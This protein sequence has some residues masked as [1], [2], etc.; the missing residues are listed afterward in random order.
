MLLAALSAAAAL[1]AATAAP[2]DPRMADLE[3]PVRP[4]VRRTLCL[5][6]L[7]RLPPCSP[8]V[9]A[10]TSDRRTLERCPVS[11]LSPQATPLIANDPYFQTYSPRGSLTDYA[12]VAGTNGKE[13]QISAIAFIEGHVCQLIGPPEKGASPAK[14]L[15]VVVYPT[16]TVYELMC[17]EAWA[18]K[19]PF[20]VTFMTAQLPSNLTLMAR[21]VSYVTFYSKPGAGSSNIQVYVD[22]SYQATSS[23]ANGDSVNVACGTNMT[24]MGVYTGWLGNAAT[25][26]TP[27]PCA[28]PLKCREGDNI[29]WG[30]LYLAQDGNPVGVGK[31]A[32]MRSKF[33]SAGTLADSNGCSSPLSGDDMPVL[34]TVFDLNNQND[35]GSPISVIFGYDQDVAIRWWGT[36]FPGLWTQESDTAEEM[37]AL[38][39][40]ETDHVSK[41][42]ETFDNAEVDKYNKIGGPKF[43]TILSLA[44]RQAYSS[45][46]LAW[47]TE[48]QTHWQ[49]LKEISTGA[50]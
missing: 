7:L 44:Y 34:A 10:P 26:S 2:V 6:H 31:S 8:R 30:Q 16:R 3:A 35:P 46:K 13:Q 42:C 11:P 22:A 28:D 19:T 36:D 21:P 4:R 29:N 23:P 27:I 41:L 20:T 18:L 39:V 50:R 17:G 14:Q 24:Q 45:T 25:Q 49:F 15:S 38:A 47:N 12:T 5:R 40:A 33:V 48:K 9:C 32:D 37:L 43:A 1:N